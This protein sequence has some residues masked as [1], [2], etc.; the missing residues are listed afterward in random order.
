[1]AFRLFLE[2]IKRL[3]DSDK[4]DVEMIVDK[5]RRTYHVRVEGAEVI[6]PKE[7]EALV[8][9]RSQEGLNDFTKLIKKIQQNQDV[10]L[11]VDLTYM[12]GLRVVVLGMKRLPESHEL[13]VRLLVDQQEQ[14]Y[15]MK[16]H[17]ERSSV[18]L[19]GALEDIAYQ[20][21]DRG[22]AFVS[23]AG[24]FYKGDIYPD[25]P[26]DLSYLKNA[27]LPIDLS[28]LSDDDYGRVERYENCGRGR[29]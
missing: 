27:E 16:F 23:L 5:G 26:E 14:T 19:P 10:Q 20:R 12:V 3:P 11:S 6:L 1:M 15:R 18:T 7:L 2:S 4:L 13:E 21:C 17:P 25:L 24:M 8:T 28:F 22:R 29:D 9:Q